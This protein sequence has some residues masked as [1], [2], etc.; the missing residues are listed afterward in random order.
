MTVILNF[1]DRKIQINN[2][3]KTMS[4]ERRTIQ[5]NNKPKTMSREEDDNSC[6][7]TSIPRKTWV[8][9]WSGVSQH[10]NPNSRHTKDMWIKAHIHYSAVLCSGWCS[11]EILMT[12]TH[13]C[14]VFVLSSG[15]CVCVNVKANKYVIVLSACTAC[16]LLP[17]FFMKMNI[18]PMKVFF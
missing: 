18:F 9:L 6:R 15:V 5:I 1:C 2:K 4:R 16:T 13:K 11:C 3:P 8:L 17:Q 12:A 14:Q 7:I 10:A